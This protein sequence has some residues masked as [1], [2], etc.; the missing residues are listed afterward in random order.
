MPVKLSNAYF[1]IDETGIL[2]IPELLS[3]KSATGVEIVIRL[4]SKG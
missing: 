3:G 1:E 2:R 4:K